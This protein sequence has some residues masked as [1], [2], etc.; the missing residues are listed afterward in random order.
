M[1]YVCAFTYPPAPVVMMERCPDRPSPSGATTPPHLHGLPCRLPRSCSTH[2]RVT[3]FAVAGADRD[4]PC[5]RRR[6]FEGIVQLRRSRRYVVV[7][8]S[9]RTSASARQGGHHRDTPAAGGSHPLRRTA[10]TTASG[11]RSCD[12]LGR[13]HGRHSRRPRRY[14]RTRPSR[15]CDLRPAVAGRQTAPACGSRSA[16]PCSGAHGV[17]VPA[18]PPRGSITASGGPH[19]ADTGRRRRRRLGAPAARFDASAA[20]CRPAGPAGTRLHPAPVHA[21]AARLHA[22]PYTPPAP[23]AAPTPTGPSAAQRRAAPTLIVDLGV[24]VAATAGA[25]GASGP[26]G[27]TGAAGTA[28][29]PGAAATGSAAAALAAGVASGASTRRTPRPR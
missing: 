25:P 10:P 8:H 6:T 2:G 16:A 1:A 14:Y 5:R 24:P 7:E 28:G 22:P 3:Y 13:S 15:R 23:Q 17:P 18:L 21:A 29:A 20:R 19:H 26:G 11:E 9:R 12:A 27:A 4:P